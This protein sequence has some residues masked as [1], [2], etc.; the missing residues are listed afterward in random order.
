M[1]TRDDFA[2]FFSMPLTDRDWANLL[3]ST[4]K[5][6][7]L[8]MGVATPKLLDGLAKHDIAV[9]IRLENERLTNPLGSIQAQV[10]EAMGRARVKAVIIGN[11]PDVAFQLTYG[12]DWGTSSLA[13]SWAALVDTVRAALSG[14]GPAIIGGALAW[15]GFVE[16][17]PPMPGQ[18]AWREILR[19][20]YNQCQGVGVHI[21][22]FGWWQYPPI[23]QFLHEL[24][25]W[26]TLWHQP[27]YL[28]EFNLVTGDNLTRMA[29]CIGAAEAILHTPALAERVEMFCPFISNGLGNAYDKGLIMQDPA[30]YTLL[31]R[32]LAGHQARALT[33]TI[34]ERHLDE[35]KLAEAEDYLARQTAPESAPQ[36]PGGPPDGEPVTDATEPYITP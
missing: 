28:D 22:A 2:L 34:A 11:E 9:V 19:D 31:A 24:R 23:A 13:W 16:S 25:Y 21:Y 27:I 30:A 12:A 7:M 4:V 8:P 35:L 10:R 3:T 33:L 20:A 1:F 15:R 29:V 6:V 18:I 26:E 32:F 5:T 17:Y 14:L 36:P